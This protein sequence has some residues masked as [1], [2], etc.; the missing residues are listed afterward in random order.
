MPA[1]ERCALILLEKAADLETRLAWHDNI[2]VP[3]PSV[4]MHGSAN[5][6]FCPPTF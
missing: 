4:F 6:E 3:L 2:A 1:M 5:V